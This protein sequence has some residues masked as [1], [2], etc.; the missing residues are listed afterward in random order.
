MRAGPGSKEGIPAVD[1][2]AQRHVLV[3]EDDPALRGLYAE[4]LVD[5]SYR[6]TLWDNPGMDMAEVWGIAPDVILLDLVFGTSDRGW[7]FLHTLRAEARTATLPVVACTG[8][9][10][11]VVTHQHT[12]DE[13]GVRIVAKPFELETLLSALREASGDPA[14]SLYLP[15]ST[16]E[17]AG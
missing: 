17:I 3:I 1:I 10:E 5:E 16:P 7:R 9:S 4:L 14:V 11:F 6:V 15:A 12:L 13:L 2:S 8:A